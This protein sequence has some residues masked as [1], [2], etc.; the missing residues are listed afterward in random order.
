M[1]QTFYEKILSVVITILIA[2]VCKSKS[3]NLT[4][5]GGI[6]IIHFVGSTD[7]ENLVTK[8]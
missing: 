5:N 6:P 3:W 2:I 4:G 1:F 7:N 8:N